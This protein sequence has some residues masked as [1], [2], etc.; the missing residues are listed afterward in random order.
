[1][2]LFKSITN[3]SPEN[4]FIRSRTNI[5]NGNINFLFKLRFNGG[6][7]FQTDEGGTDDNYIFFILEILFDVDS[8]SVVT[9]GENIFKGVDSWNGRYSWTAT[10]GNK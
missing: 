1:M 2:K 7:S 10:S 8:I 9:K 5:N 6:G 3:F 4:T